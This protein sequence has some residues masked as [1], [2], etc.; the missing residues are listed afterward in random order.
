MKIGGYEYEEPWRC[1]AIKKKSELRCLHPSK[2]NG[3]CNQHYRNK[4]DETILGLYDELKDDLEDILE[5]GWELE[6]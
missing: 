4:P 5:Y 2:V 1:I 3:L 6:L